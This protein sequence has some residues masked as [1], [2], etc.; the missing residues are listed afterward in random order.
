MPPKSRRPSGMIATPPWHTSWG[1]A[2]VTSTPSRRSRP[3][4][5]GRRR[6]MALISVVLP[7]PLGPTT[8]TS[9]PSPTVSETSHR[10]GASPYPTCRPS[11][12]S[13]G[14]P[15]IG[16][17]DLRLPDDVARPALGDQLAVVQ[18]HDPVGQVDHGPHDVLDEEDGGAPPADLPHERER[19]ADLR[20][21]QA[22]QDLVQEDE[23]GPRG[24]RA[25]E[26]EELAL[27]QVQR[28]RQRRGAVG[29]PDEVE[30]T[31]GLPL[32]L[33]TV[34]GRAAEHAGEGDVIENRQ[35]RERPRDLIR[36]SD[37]EPGD[38]MAGLVG[39]VPPVEED[40]ARVGTVIAADDV[41]ERRLAGAVGP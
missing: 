11:A 14:F 16:G 3:R 12:S 17:H 30:P 20:G 38:A 10:A 39:E 21:R 4:R 40:A 23:P 35:A 37:A 36:A 7:A 15:E 33:A 41:D 8:A 28:R 5:I 9:S 2:R 6:A 22:R 31:A 19:L 29:E 25:R 34:E 1:V 27:M 26:L 24:Q 18:H 13:I 32:G